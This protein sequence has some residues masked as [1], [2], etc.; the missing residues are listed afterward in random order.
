MIASLFGR[1]LRATRC[2]W[3]PVGDCGWAPTKNSGPTFLENFSP[4]RLAAP[5]ALALLAGQVT[6]YER[7]RLE[8]D[9]CCIA[10]AIIYIYP[11]RRL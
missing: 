10:S 7:E 9:S 5:L 6:K 1:G 3:L 2:L 8:S 4:D 11:L